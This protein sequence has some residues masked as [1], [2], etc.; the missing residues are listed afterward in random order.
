[1]EMGDAP[2]VYCPTAR[3][4]AFDFFERRT[5]PAA[6]TVIALTSDIRPDLPVGLEGR[7]CT[8]ADEVEVERAGRQV[9]HYFVHSCPPVAVDSEKRA[10]RDEAMTVSVAREPSESPTTES[11]AFVAAT[12]RQRCVRT[13]ALAAR[14]RRSSRS[15]PGAGGSRP[16]R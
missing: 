15:A 5:P 11:G 9:A 12:A 1:M 6:A 3:R 2:N 14:A 13:S 16:A 7:A 10:S 8:L 4:S